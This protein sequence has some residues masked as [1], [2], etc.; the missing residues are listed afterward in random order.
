MTTS[1]LKQPEARTTSGRR[2]ITDWAPEDPVYWARTGRRI[3]HRNLAFS[4]L[5]EH[6]G[7]SVWLMWS[8]VAVMLPAAGFPFTADQL[9]WIVAMPNLVG[10]VAR[11]PYTAAVARFGGRN[12][13][14]VAAG[15]LLVPILLLALCVTNPSTPYWMFQRSD[16][17]SV[18]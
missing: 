1:S 16:R 4:I 7:F 3:A 15:L 6:L 5:A 11:I 9:F 14:V 8:V 17:K 12:W 10:A 18:V 13:T 2:W